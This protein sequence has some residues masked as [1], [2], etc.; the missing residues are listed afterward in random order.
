MRFRPTSSG[1][2]RP[3]DRL[4]TSASARISS[5]G[6]MIATYAMLKW[7]VATANLA[8][9]YLNDAVHGLIVPVCDQFL[10][11]RHVAAWHGSAGG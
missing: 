10:A 3:N 4:N 11:S 7:A 2:R 9:S 1:V 8:G 5:P 6:E